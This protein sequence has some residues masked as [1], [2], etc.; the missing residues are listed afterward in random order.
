MFAC[1]QERSESLG[2]ICLAAILAVTL[3]AAG[4]L[5]ASPA[6]HEYLHH[7]ATSTHVCA[8]TLFASG[9][10]EAAGPLPAFEAPDPLPLLA[11]LPLPTALCFSQ[12]RFFSLLEHAPPSFA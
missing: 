1:H 10:C 3:L 12:A 6:L 7:D 9:H 4:L 8:V 11:V 5:S 2:K